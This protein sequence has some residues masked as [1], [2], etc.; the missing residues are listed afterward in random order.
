M[1]RPQIDFKK[2]LI[3]IVLIVVAIFFFGA[4]FTIMIP[5]ATSSREKIVVRR[6]LR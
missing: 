1:E 3:D 5:A 4:I 2:I 6:V